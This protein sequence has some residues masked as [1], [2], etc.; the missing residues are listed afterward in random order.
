MAVSCPAACLDHQQ[1]AAHQSCPA[2]Q[3]SIGC[4]ASDGQHCL[5]ET[6]QPCVYCK[7]LACCH[8]QAA[9]LWAR[10]L[11]C[12]LPH[13]ACLLTWASSCSPS[14]CQSDLC[15]AV[16]SCGARGQLVRS[17]CFTVC[18]RISRNWP[19]Y[20]KQGKHVPLQPP[21]VER[22]GASVQLDA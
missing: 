11:S 8:V 6:A 20:P 5:V 19:T 13:P 18:G 12:H 10:A 7:N 16:V 1:A 9:G 15:C 4:L 2:A 22:V 14:F 3:H 17:C 21:P